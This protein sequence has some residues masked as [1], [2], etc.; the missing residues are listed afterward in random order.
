MAGFWEALKDYQ[1]IIGAGLNAVIS[2]S[3]AL[4]IARRV[5]ERGRIGF[6]SNGHRIFFSKVV[7][8]KLPRN[9]AVAWT[10]KEANTVRVFLD[11]DIYNGSGIRKTLR[12][13][14]LAV[15]FRWEKQLLEGHVGISVEEDNSRNHVEMLRLDPKEIRRIE[16]TLYFQEPL[17]GLIERKGNPRF[18]FVYHDE[19]NK[20]YE[21]HINGLPDLRDLRMREGTQ[22]AVLA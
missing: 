18:T 19:R 20:R 21:V 17:I 10:L 8:S 15:R 4:F 11:Y 1:S 16:I 22:G 14:T 9:E 6:F 2:T 5:A 7:E 12:A 3:I 13:F